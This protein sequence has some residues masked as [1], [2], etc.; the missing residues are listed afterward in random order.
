MPKSRTRGRTRGR[1]GVRTSKQKSKFNK[2]NSKVYRNSRFNIK[3]MRREA[4]KEDKMLR[5]K[6]E[7]HLRREIKQ[8]PK[9]YRYKDLMNRVYKTDNDMLKQMLVKQANP[10]DFKNMGKQVDKLIKEPLDINIFFK[11][12]LI[13]WVVQDKL[14]KHGIKPGR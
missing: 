1:V 7:L 5:K 14:V 10:K 2:R 6:I 12:I 3:T 9:D 8:V 11:L 4:N 13:F